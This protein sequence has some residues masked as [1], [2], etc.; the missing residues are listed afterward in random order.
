MLTCVLAV[1]LMAAVL[2]HAPD[3]TLLI[4]RVT[5]A[6]EQDGSAAQAE[7]TKKP[8][9]SGKSDKSGKVSKSGKPKKAKASKP[10]PDEDRG[11][12]ESLDAAG[13]QIDVAGQQIELTGP[14]VPTP[15]FEWKQHPSL[16]FGRNFRLN[17]EAKL[18]E[19]AHATHPDAPGL[20][21]AGATLPSACDWEF[22]RNRIGVSGKVGKHIDFE[23]VR[24]LTEQELTEKQLILGETAKSQ[25]KDVNVDLDYFKRAQIQVG[26]FKVPFGLDEL[27]GVTHN[28]FVYRSLGAMYLS[29]GRDVGGQVH[30]RFFK[31][32]LNY[33]AGLFQHD[34]DNARSKKIEG[35]NETFAARVTGAPFRRGMAP[36]FGDLELGGAFA[37]SQLS[38]DSFR[39]NGFRGRTVI[40]QDYFYESVYVKGTRRRFETDLDWTA[41]PASVR[42]EYTHVLDGRQAQGLG[43]EDLPDARA[44]AWYVSGTWALTGDR[45]ARPFKPENDFLS[46]GMGGVEVAARYERL[47]FD[48]VDATSLSGPASRTPRA[49]AILSS[50]NRVLTLG[51]NWT[52]NRFWKLQ[53]NAIREHLENPLVNPVPGHD[54]FWSRVLRF[55][56]VL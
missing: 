28:D 35:G 39:P 27:T 8:K 42:A 33:W 2:A 25:W 17:F 49:D 50:G 56:L 41:G 54:A 52:L 30:G 36:R 21:C 46:G 23:I 32:G 12:I 6:F 24:E 20:Q 13:Q 19:D 31:R 18:Q 14:R 43:D 3:P 7:T 29:P 38:N 22:H 1:P 40:A 53:L 47:W 10:S 51:V 45:K 4:A 9:K 48:S 55:Q 15:R 34:G 11:A 26:K 5:P 37:V 44:R 16:R